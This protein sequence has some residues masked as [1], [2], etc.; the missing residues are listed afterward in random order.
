MWQTKQYPDAE[1]ESLVGKSYV[2]LGYGASNQPSALALKLKLEDN[3]ILC[4]S[5]C[6]ETEAKDVLDL[7][8]SN[9]WALILIL[10]VEHP[11]VKDLFK[12]A[13]TKKKAI[14][15][16]CEPK[17]LDL[18][19]ALESLLVAPKFLLDHEDE[20]SNNK[21]VYTILLM[22]KEHTL[23][24]RIETM[25]KS[26]VLAKKELELLGVVTYEEANESATT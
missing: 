1:K 23:V 10:S 19:P 3:G 9:S 4:W 20:E 15:L 5:G 24:T 6:L 8:I 21:L 12:V 17:Y 25:E 16:V 14:L 7:H 11:I 22:Q 13:T 18:D 2:C 26:L